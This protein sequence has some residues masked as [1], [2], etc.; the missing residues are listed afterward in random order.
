MSYLPEYLLTPQE[1]VSSLY[2]APFNFAYRTDDH[3][4][5]WVERPENAQRLSQFGRAMTGARS[6]EGR[7]NVTDLSGMRF[8]PHSLIFVRR[9]TRTSLSAFPWDTLSENSLVVDVGGGIGSVSVQ[10]A[11]KYPALR[12]VVQDREQTIAEAPKIWG[13]QHEHLFASGRVVFQSQDFFD[14]QPSSY[15]IQGVG[16]VKN[17]RVF[18]LTRVL[19]NWR[20]EDSKKSVALDLGVIS[21]LTQAHAFFRILAALRASA[22]PE[23]NLVV[24][25]QCLPLA[26]TSESALAPR[27]TT[28]LPN[29]G[30]AY[31]V[32][33][34]LDLIVSILHAIT[35]GCLRLQGFELGVA[36][37]R[38]DGSEGEDPA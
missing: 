24:V 16:S 2:Q 15:Q 26:C 30:K 9:L 19:H 8:A 25:D 4:Y 17:P 18:L 21:L 5:S 32:G 28:L 13:D 34:H 14:P 37:V 38:P 31:A 35:L 23:T 1:G 3:F 29:L 20:D 36:D 10:L 27:D 6:V 11:D 7:V 22:S 33:Y 12:I